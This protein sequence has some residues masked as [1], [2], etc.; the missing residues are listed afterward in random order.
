MS[1]DIVTVASS[2]SQKKIFTK[3]KGVVCTSKVRQWTEHLHLLEAFTV[4]AC[5]WES[6]ITPFLSVTSSG[7]FL[8]AVQ[9]WKKLNLKGLL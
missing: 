1:V 9:N 4:T 5:F 6:K 3:H 7:F 2:G 8:Q